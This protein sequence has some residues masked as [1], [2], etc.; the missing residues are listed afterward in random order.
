M[1]K[2]PNAEYMY[3]IFFLNIV[4]TAIAWLKNIYHERFIGCFEQFTKV[5]LRS[6]IYLLL[7]VI[8]FLFFFRLML[9]SRLFIIIVLSVI[10]IALLA[11]RL[12]YF[13]TYQYLKKT[14]RKENKVVII[15]YNSLSK[16][17]VSYL[18]EDGINEIVG[19]CEEY[20]NIHELSRYP[21][22]SEVADTLDVCKKYGVNEIYSTI[23]PEHN[24]G[25][26]KLI[27][28]AEDNCI[29]FRIVPDLGL[30]IKRQMYIDY[31]KEIPIIS[32]RKEP[33][34]DWGNRI[35]KRV[36]DIVISLFA[37]IFIL[38]WLIPLISL[39][40]WL[41]SGGPVFFI[42]QR[43]GKNN[44]TFPCIKFRSMR[45]NKNANIQ[46]ATRQDARITRVGKFLR[47]TSLDEFP[48][49]LNVLTGDMSISGPR[50]HMLKHTDEYS[51]LIGQYMV[52]QFVKPG[53]TGWAQVNG[54][55][56]E[57]KNVFQMQKRVEH[58]LWYLENWNLLLDIKIVFMTMLNVVRGE[59]NAY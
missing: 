43:S 48:Q 39:L 10:P 20:Q 58:D 25:L 51:K 13:F 18:S 44:R 3:F 6:Y 17:L 37:V 16:K 59:K 4:W 5:T 23:A 38:S 22:L 11:N 40:I 14:D 15:G 42:Q 34:D 50:P 47:R 41:D 49:F 26:Y 28:A 9:I 36:F 53:I 55:R 45:F 1:H 2:R 8:I 46:Q 57:T 54:F 7:A 30:F 27:Q 19:F 12:I 31:L 29:R 21:I 56:G 35:S 24:P 52:R 32:L 33:L